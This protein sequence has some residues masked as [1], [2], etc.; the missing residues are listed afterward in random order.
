MPLAAEQVYNDLTGEEAKEILVTRFADL[1]SQYP[2]FKRHITLPRVQM[3]LSVHL[4]LW[5]C[6]PP[7]TDIND[8]VVIRTR[9]VPAEVEQLSSADA[10]VEIDSR[11]TPPDQVRTEHG[12]PIMTPTRT[13][14]G[15]QDVPVVREGGKY[16]K[17]VVQDRGGPA[18]QGH[19]QYQDP[20]TQA[21][22]DHNPHRGAPEI[23]IQADFRNMHRRNTVE[24]EEK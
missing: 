3:T 21:H 1:L 7:T 23:G 22:A 5:G 6:T 20:I 9:E 15:I 10:Q 12:M 14:D 24:G 11:N 2:Y 4:D 18:S 17:F 16:A 19:L 8:E 13:P